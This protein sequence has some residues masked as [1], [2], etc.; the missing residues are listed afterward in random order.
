MT[1]PPEAPRPSFAAAGWALALAVAGCCLVGNVVSTALARVV[2]KRSR[3]TGLD[4]G[5]GLAIAA[6]AI[7]ASVGGFI[8]LVVFVAFGMGLA[9]VDS[10]HEAKEP[11]NA[12]PHVF[13]D[14][15]TL[16]RGDCVNV[17]SISGDGGSFNRR[18][19]CNQLHDAEVTHLFTVAGDRFPGDRAIAHEGDTC[20]KQPFR[21][22]VGIGFDASTLDSRY[23]YPNRDEWI[24]GER[25]IV[26][27]AADPKG[28]VKQSLKGSKR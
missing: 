11:V 3:E 26:C 24:A 4:H 6:L 1:A 23:F 27:L 2:L 18:V 7:N 16:D 28:R 10:A 9:F 13:V 12:D 19:P 15:D 17:P 22:Y 8:G 20:A 21:D 25:A 14:V 5:N